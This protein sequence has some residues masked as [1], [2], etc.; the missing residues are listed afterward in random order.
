MIYP[1]NFP[2]ESRLT[3]SVPKPGPLDG[4]HCSGCNLCHSSL[5]YTSIDLL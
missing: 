2:P 1:T 3:A 4:I 5:K